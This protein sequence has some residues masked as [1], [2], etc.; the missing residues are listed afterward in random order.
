[1]RELKWSRQWP[2]TLSAQILCVSSLLSMSRL[3]IAEASVSETSEVRYRRP[4]C[5]QPDV[6]ESRSFKQRI[7]LIISL[8]LVRKEG[9]ST[10]AVKVR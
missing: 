9:S 5:L 10:H 8:T 4:H 1:M 3:N 6:R 7:F 2:G